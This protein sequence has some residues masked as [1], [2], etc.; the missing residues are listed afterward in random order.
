MFQICLL[1]CFQRQVARK[2]KDWIAADNGRDKISRMGYTLV[3]VK[4]GGGDD[5]ATQIIRQ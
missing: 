3:D 1:L 4:G 5:D 2:A